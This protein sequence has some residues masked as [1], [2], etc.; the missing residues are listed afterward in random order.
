[1]PNVVVLGLQWGDEGK[2]RFID[3]L[4]SEVDIVAR[5]QGGSNAGHTVVCDGQKFIFH[6]VPSGVLRPGKVNVVGNGVVI[7]PEELMKEIDELKARGVSVNDRLL[8][9]DR[10]QVVLPYHKRLDAAQEK[11]SGGK[12]GTTLRGIGPAYSHKYLRIG[13]RMGDIIRP[14]RAKALLK[15]QLPGINAVLKK[16][17]GQKA[18][19]E[20]SLLKFLLS[21]G[22]KLKSFVTDTTYY[23]N[24]QTEAG[25]S[26]LFEGAQATLLDIDFGTYP[27]VTSSNPSAGGVST[28]TGIPPKLVGRVTGVLK[29]Y[30]TRVGSGP[31]PTEL[32]S[33][34]GQQLREAGG[35]YG[36]TTGRPRRCGWLDAVAARYS[37]MLNGVDEIAF[38]KLDVLSGQ[39]SVKIAVAYSYRGKITDRFPAD[40]DVLSKVKPIYEEMP[41]W[42]NEIRNVREFKALPA[43]A[44][45]YVR[46]VEKLIGVP[47]KFISVGEQREQL[48]VR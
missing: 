20:A 6:L 7:D 19:S 29:A 12:I 42:S 24:E 11:K 28:G 15:E 4:A 17:Y 33:A 31:F 27:Y 39:K 48:I 25:K 16:I 34:H 14:A 47:I 23:L 26:I 22:K 8:V 46:R 43:S 36:A 32:K 10:A 35:E 18:V 41:G 5:Y 40:P 13:M 45:K 30:T 3:Y 44:K 9:S 1:M 21:Y 37:V 2:A 38:S